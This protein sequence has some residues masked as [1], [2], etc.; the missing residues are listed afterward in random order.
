MH[1]LVILCLQLFT[2]NANNIG[3]YEPT[4]TSV[5]CS[6]SNPRDL[7]IYYLDWRHACV[8]LVRPTPLNI[9][10]CTDAIKMH[11]YLS[12]GTLKCFIECALVRWAASAP[13]SCL[14]WSTLMQVVR[15]AEDWNAELLS[16]SWVNLLLVLLH[17]EFSHPGD[18]L[19]NRS[20]RFLRAI[21]FHFHSLFFQWIL[22][23]EISY[24]YGLNC[25][26]VIRI[27][28]KLWFPSFNSVSVHGI[29]VSS[30]IRA[31]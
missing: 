17:A 2:A 22:N 29:L 23:M 30:V 21:N 7:R 25:S 16:R 27:H 1:F 31:I 3:R 8:H 6:P 4:S 19:L 9:L 24:L 18:A 5:N 20:R 11:F 10:C 26:D 12:R 13:A 28:I 15:S 14:S